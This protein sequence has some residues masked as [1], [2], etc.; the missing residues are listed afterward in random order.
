MAH[1]RH[2]WPLLR[3]RIY[4]Q[5]REWETD[6]GSVRI[7]VGDLV[8]DPVGYRRVGFAATARFFCDS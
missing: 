8:G 2:T 6:S 1:T 5:I 3:I 4:G 7:V